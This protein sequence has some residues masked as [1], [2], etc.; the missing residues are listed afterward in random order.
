M[1][2]EIPEPEAT[3]GSAFDL[4]KSGHLMSAN[5]MDRLLFLLVSLQRLTTSDLKEKQL[6]PYRAPL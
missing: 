2:P 3:D 1:W 6:C 4:Q 5:G